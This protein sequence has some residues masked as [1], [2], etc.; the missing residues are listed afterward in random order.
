MSFDPDEVRALLVAAARARAPLTYADAL[1]AFGH[2]FTRPLMRQFCRALDEVDA[3]TAGAGEPAL[4][5]LVV[6]QS[7]GLPGQGWWLGQRGHTGAWDG[8]E[9]RAYVRALQERAFAWWSARP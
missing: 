7:D 1:G 8:P 6:R 3:P 2:R 4:A 9:A 5:V